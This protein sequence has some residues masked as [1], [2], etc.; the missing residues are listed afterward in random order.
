[1]NRLFV[2]FAVQELLSIEMKGRSVRIFGSVHYIIDVHYCCKVNTDLMS[3]H[4]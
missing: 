4:A 1:M 3:P 2:M